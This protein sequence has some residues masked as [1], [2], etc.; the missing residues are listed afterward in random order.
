MDQ[1]P[2][3]LI[4][5]RQL[6]ECLALPVFVIDHDGALVFYNEPA[7]AILGLRFEETGT[8]DLDQWSSAFRP[9]D[10]SGHPLEP[11]ELPIVLALRGARPASGTLWITG[12]DRVPRKIHVTAFPLLTRMRRIA[13]AAAVFGEVA[14]PGP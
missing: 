3:E 12:L 6:A 4:L 8:L 11:E 9:V 7:E 2:L 5:T 14:S 10:A 1:K 13:G